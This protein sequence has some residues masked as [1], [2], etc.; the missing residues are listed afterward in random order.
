MTEQTNELTGQRIGELCKQ[1]LPGKNDS[2]LLKKI[3]ALAP[4]MAVRLAKTGDEWYQIGGVVSADGARISNDLIEWVD[5]TYVECGHDFQVLIDH[6]IKQQLIATR[7]IGKT[8]YFVIET[9]TQAEDFILLEI[10]KTQ[11]VSDRLLVNEDCL[12]EDQEDIIDPLTPATIES[13]NLGHSRYQYRRKTDIKLFMKNLNE[14]HA[15]DEHPVQRF[16]TDWNNSS[17][18]KTIFCKDWIIRPYQTTGRYGEQVINA[19]VINI[20]T[21]PLPHLEDMF[22]K[23]GNTLHNL[24]TRFDRQAGYTFAWYFYMVK[25]KLVAPHNGEAVYRDIT[26]DFAYLPQRDEAIL[27]NWIASPYNV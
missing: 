9:G 12:P 22:G 4:D 21:Q 15:G 16:M 10:D 18:G 2:S 13:Y 27:R 20:Q 6:A 11:E 17:A 19:E 24:L 26:G 14:H 23:H 5:R 3:Q 7:I 25:G 8:L 1:L